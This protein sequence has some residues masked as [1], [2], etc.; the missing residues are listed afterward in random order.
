MKM[1]IKLYYD[2]FKPATPLHQ[3]PFEFELLSSYTFPDTQIIEKKERAPNYRV[4][5]GVTISNAITNMLSRSDLAEI[6]SRL[7]RFLPDDYK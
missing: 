5:E 1:I 4:R 3:R 2:R 6:G 7:Q